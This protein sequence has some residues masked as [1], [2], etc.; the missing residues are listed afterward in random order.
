MKKM[1]SR[2]SGKKQKR[3]T[4]RKTDDNTSNEGVDN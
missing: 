1:K 2:Q 3:Q 4:M